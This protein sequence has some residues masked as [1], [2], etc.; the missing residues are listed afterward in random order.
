MLR[1]LVALPRRRRR[2]PLRRCERHW[3]RLGHGSLRWHRG[4]SFVECASHT[5]V[6]RAV[7][8][9]ALVPLL[10]AP[11]TAVAALLVDARRRW[12]PAGVQEGALAA[13]LAEALHE[14]DARLAAAA[15]AA[16][17]LD[18]VRSSCHL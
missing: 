5:L 14:E 17:A 16:A 15:A 10:A 12:Q 8:E 18:V 9:G 7:Q 3:R 13:G 1:V 4:F 11:A 6:R 2:R